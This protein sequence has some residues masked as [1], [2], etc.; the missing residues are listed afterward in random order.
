MMSRSINFLFLFLASY[1]YAQQLPQFTQF[2]NNVSLVNNANF[3]NETN[4]VNIGARSQ[5]LGFGLEPNS[6]FVYG[7]YGL[8]KKPQPNYNPQIRISKPIPKEVIKPS[9]I[10]HAIAAIALIDRYGA[11]SRTHLSGI[12]NLGYK[13]NSNW[14]LSGS[15]K[16]GLSS[17]G[18]NSDKAVV[19]N[20]NDPFAD[21][22]NGDNEYDG[23]VSGNTRATTID[24]GSAIFVS[25]KSFEAGLS[26]EQ[27]AGNALSFTNGGVNFN[28]KLHYNILLGYNYQLSKVNIEL[29]G[30]FKQMSPAPIS[31]DLSAR[32]AFENGFWAGINYRHSSALGFLVGMNFSKSIRLGYSYDFITNRLNNFSYGGHELILGYAF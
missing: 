18:F 27:L 31:I 16:L 1:T 24:L 22:V 8:K 23:F 28:Q 2:S 9:R 19:L 25:S 17:L 13:I 15:L 30:L 20:S 5:M 11:F 6:A 21:Y 32:A 12:Y 3:I 26:C 4:S 7:S 29:V 14:N 10:Q